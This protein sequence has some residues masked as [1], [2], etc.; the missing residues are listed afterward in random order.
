MELAKIVT[1]EEMIRIETAADA[2]GH[3]YAEMM[4]QAGKSLA[5]A[6]LTRISNVKGK[7]VLVL[8]G[9]GNNGGDG[10]VAARW[11]VEAGATLAVYLTKE[12]AKDDPHLAALRGLGTL[13]AISEQDQRSRVLKLQLGRAD[14]VVDAVLGT[15]FKLPLRGAA[16]QVLKVAKQNDSRPFVVAVD[17]PSGLDCDTGEIANETLT[18]DLT[19]TL[20]AAKPG[21]FLFPGAEHVGELVIGDIGLSDRQKEL[22]S[23]KSEL[24]TAESARELLP[25]RPMDAHKGSFGRALIVAGSIN[26][27]GAAA[28]AGRAAYLAGAGLVTLAVPA[29]VQAMIAGQLPECTWLPLG[30]TLDAEN[31]RLLGQE[32][33]HTQAL[34]VGPGF[35][36]ESATA[37]FLRTLL[38]A[39]AK[40]PPAVIDAD[41]LKLMAS[42]E[43]WDSMLPAGSVLTPHPGEMSVLT[44]LSTREIQEHRSE[45]ALEKAAEWGH[46]VVLKGAFT[47]IAHPDGR[48]TLIPTATPALARAGTGDVL[49]GLL[50]GYRAQGLSSYEASVVG[51]YL[52]ARAG[53]LAA[54]S[55][56]TAASVLAGDVAAAV[57][58]A[59]AELEQSPPRS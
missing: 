23:I 31:A 37:D 4:E 8:A 34:L 50:V 49:A 22:A 21:L 52:H 45:I 44:G 25:I 27:P 57:P 13:I 18:A 16:E 47:V 10:L 1:V 39:G 26:F 7:H 14:I 2:G 46:I 48:S 6:L 42:V 59:I 28:L 41:G 51:S 30:V 54:Q 36:L 33:E 19:V 29:P 24:A 17:C 35:G 3:S 58:A 12:R 9:T 38:E 40:L 43:G 5:N 55:I 11:L 20:A 15:G 56:G 32:W 53:Q